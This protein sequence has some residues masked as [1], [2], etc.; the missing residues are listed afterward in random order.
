MLRRQMASPG[1][2]L[3]LTRTEWVATWTD[4]GE[5]PLQLASAYRNSERG[6]TKTPDEVIHRQLHGISDRDFERIAK[7]GPGATAHIRIGE[8]VIGGQTRGRD[9]HFDQHHS[10]GLILCLS[11]SFS[12]DIIRRLNKK[13]C[14]EIAD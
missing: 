4:G 11:N 14:V 6:G 5:I 12:A 2:Y 9:V 1:K 7:I 13:A 8:V 3:Y 10:D